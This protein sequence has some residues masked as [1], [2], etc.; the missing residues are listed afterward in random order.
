[1]TEI[2]IVMGDYSSDLL[3]NING[4]YGERILKYDKIKKEYTICEFDGKTWIEIEQTDKPIYVLINLQLINYTVILYKKKILNINKFFICCNCEKITINRLKYLN[5]EF[6]I[7]CFFQKN[8]DNPNRKE[9]DIPPLTIGKYI[10]KNEKKHNMNN[11]EYPS[12]CFLCDYKKGKILFDIN[13]SELIYKDK[14]IDMIK[15][16]QLEIII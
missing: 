13:D 4:K 3:N 10:F 16:K 5:T 8:Y 15:K 11:C 9:Y 6:C 12:R 7:H 1:M 14:L 2:Q